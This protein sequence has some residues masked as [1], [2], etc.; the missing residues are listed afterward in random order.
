MA[1]N[2][3]LSGQTFPALGLVPSPEGGSPSSTPS[4]RSPSPKLVDQKFRQDEAFLDNLLS[5]MEGSLP[6]SLGHTDPIGSTKSASGDN[7]NSSRLVANIEDLSSADLKVPHPPS[8]G[9]PIPPQ[10]SPDKKWG[11][12]EDG[13][14]VREPIADKRPGSRQGAMGT[15]MTCFGESEV[16]GE[17]DCQPHGMFPDADEMKRNVRKALTKPTYNVA[18]LYHEDGIWRWLA[19][20]PVFENMTL[21]VI[22]VNAL[23]MA[24][25]TDNNKAVG[26]LTAEQGFQIM[27]HAFCF[28]FSFEWLVRFCAFKRKRDGMRDGWFVFDTILVFLMVMETWVVSLILLSQGAGGGGM[29]G[30]ASLLRIFRLM[31]LTRLARMLRSMPELM[32]LIKGM[33]AASR[34]VGFTLALICILLYVFAILLTQLTADPAMT[35]LNSE[36]GENYFKT[37]PESMYTLLIYGTFLDN[38]AA[39]MED[40]RQVSFILA[41]IFLIFIALSAL[42]VMNML[43]GVLC[44][45]VS[46]VAATE[47]EQ[48][49]VEFVRTKMEK[50]VLALDEDG[51]GRISKDEFMKILTNQEAAFALQEVGV[52]PEGLVDFIDS[53]FEKDGQEIE[54]LDFPE[55][56]DVVLD[57]RAENGATV[58]D[59]M[60]LTKVINRELRNLQKALTSGGFGSQNTSPMASPRRMSKDS[61][62]GASTPLKKSK[63]KPQPQLPGQVG[64][65]T[66]NPSPDPKQAEPRPI[67]RDAAEV[68]HRAEAFLLAGQSELQKLLQPAEGSTPGTSAQMQ[69]AIKTH[70]ELTDNLEDLRRINRGKQW[71]DEDEC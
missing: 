64:D 38:L 47:K 45:V 39:V 63:Q 62:R 36:N 52:D 11:A 68:M 25:D 13:A 59:V 3:L 12:A 14:L 2:L 44:E 34:S 69:W 66:P 8:L 18:D 55:F 32:I 24:Y 1:G 70:K 65:S 5:T 4:E 6:N 19:V 46:A 58:K 71:Q 48:M 53:I 42:M 29:P 21:G 60:K 33:V 26:L 23:W 61:G 31:R 41:T 67:A 28:Y 49:R 10:A 43:I 51:S 22:T 35:V 20:N 37:I 27:E 54:D 40:I 30:N 17:D 56:M 9:L 57:M 15:M 7:Q 50:I 16:E